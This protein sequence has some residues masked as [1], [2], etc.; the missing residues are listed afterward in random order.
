MSFIIDPY[1]FGVPFGVGTS[2]RFKST[3]IVGLSNSDPVSTW[4]DLSGNA[5]DATASGSDR[6][7]YIADGGLGVPCVRFNGSNFL[8]LT[9]GISSQDLSIYCVLKADRSAG[10]R[11]VIGG[12]SSGS[13]LLRT[14]STSRIQ[15]EFLKNSVA[16]IGQTTDDMQEEAHYISTVIYSSPNLSYFRNGIANGTAS[17]SA[18]FTNPINRIG[19][20]NGESNWLGD[21]YEIRIYPVAHNSTE[22]AAVIT[23]LDTD[24]PGM[25][26]LATGIAS[27]PNCLGWYKAST[28]GVANN[29]SLSGVTWADSS[30]LGNDLLGSGTVTYKTSVINGL[31]AVEFGGGYFTLKRG[32]YSG[33]HTIYM[34]LKPTD[35]TTRTICSAYQAG[36]DVR[37]NSSKVNYLKTAVTD[38]GSGTSTISLVAFS[39]ANV[40]Y[41]GSTITFRQGS[42]ANGTVSD[43]RDFQR[44]IVEIGRNA[45]NSGELFQGQIAELC[46]FQ[47]V[48]SGGD[49]TTAEADLNS[50]YGV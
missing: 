13:P 24:W 50:R 6:P 21:F 42:S 14:N 44:A 16:S 5:N 30:G 26:T 49:K 48:H 46:F 28:I 31:D 15:Y 4:S 43:S 40:S 20:G 41:D 33:N 2:V 29:T 9:S 10:Q 17:T 38:M 22:R 11:A 1:R 39:Q 12:S 18:T 37:I 34:V 36:T 47:G 27:L 8:A 19:A 7:T 23:E 25:V 32:I 35:G 3:S 45:H